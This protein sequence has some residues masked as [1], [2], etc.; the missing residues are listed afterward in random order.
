LKQLWPQQPEHS[1]SSLTP[2][3]MTPVDMTP[4]DMEPLDMDRAREKIG[5][6][7]RKVIAFT[8]LV[9]SASLLPIINPIGSQAEEALN[10]GACKLQAAT[11]L[12]VKFSK[13]L[14][15]KAL[16]NPGL[17]I[18]DINSGEEVYNN[19]AETPRI[20]ASVMKVLTGFTALTFLGGSKQ[21]NTSIYSIESSTSMVIIGESDPWMTMYRSVSAKYGPAYAPDL[22]QKA[23]RDNLDKLEIFYSGLYPSDVAGLRAHFI[24]KGVKLKFVETSRNSAELLAKEE[25]YSISSATVDQMVKF[26]IRYSDNRLSDRLAQL[27]AVAH[28]YKKNKKGLQATYEDALLGLAIGIDGLNIQDGSGLSKSNR[29]SSRTVVEV[30][31]KTRGQAQFKSLY[32]GMPTSGKTGTLKPRFK[33][34]APKA[35]GLVR[36]KTGWVNGTVSLAGYVT[37]GEK[38][39]VFAVLADRIPWTYSG[40]ERARAAI[41]RLVG[42]LAAPKRQAL[43]EQ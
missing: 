33:K 22:I 35:V 28:G 10:N 37:S 36:A 38:E 16:A 3:D 30:L 40:R 41:D 9:L 8:L 43:V 27:A 6:Q 24:A 19:L 34:T 29:V 4:L 13:Q 5:G 42:S 12:P 1:S 21:F 17:L 25:L 15:S 23:N 39:L 18:V 11:C 26:L 32:Q 2:V 31:A 14:N 7:M 20:P